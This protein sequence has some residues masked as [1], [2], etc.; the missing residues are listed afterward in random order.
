MTDKEEQKVFLNDNAEFEYYQQD[1]NNIYYIDNEQ[2]F[3]V[4]LKDVPKVSDNLILNALIP[5]S[6]AVDII[7]L[8]VQIPV[9]ENQIGK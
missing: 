4:S 7:T 2:I 8:P 9:L 1:H 6:T 5:V 3:Y